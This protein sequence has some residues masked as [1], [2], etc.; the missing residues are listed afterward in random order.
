[1]AGVV[2]IIIQT[3]DESTGANNSIIGSFT[4]L[5][6]AVALASEAVAAGKGI[7]DATIGST[8]RYADSVREISAVSGTSTE[9]TSRLI[10]VTEKL[11]VQQGTLEMA[12][13]FLAKEGIQPT[14]QNMAALSDQY[15]KLAPGVERDTF[16]LQNFGRSG[17]DMAVFMSQGSSAIMALNE[18]VNKNLILTAQQVEAFH[19][20]S[21]QQ[22]QVSDNWKGITTQFSIALMPAVLNVTTAFLRQSESM[23]IATDMGFNNIHMTQQQTAE[24]NN[25]IDAENNYGAA[26]DA[27]DRHLQNSIDL[28]AQQSDTVKQQ[29]KDINSLIKDIEN[30][31]KEQERY[32]TTNEQLLA[33]KADIIGAYD[34]GRISLA[35]EN[36]ELQTVNAALDKNAADHAAWAKQVIFSMLQARVAAQETL[37]PAHAGSYQDFLIKAGE[38]MGMFD[39][40]T[41]QVMQSVNDSISSLNTSNA[42]QALTTIQQELQYLQANGVVNIQVN[43]T[44]SGSINIPAGT[45]TGA[46]GS[47]C[48]FPAGTLIRMGDGGD[49][50][51]EDVQ[52]GDRVKAFDGFAI[53]DAEVT[54]LIA[55]IRDHLY[56]LTFA[57]GTVL[58]LTREHPIFTREGWKSV[59]PEAT[60]TTN[61]GLD[62]KTLQVGDEILTILGEFIA[63]TNIEYFYGNVQTYNLTGV[64]PCN[65]YF[66]NGYLVHNKNCA[67]GGDFIVPPGYPGD[68]YP[69]S[70]TSGE[71]VSITP[72]GRSAEGGSGMTIN[73]FNSQIVMPESMTMDDVMKA[74]NHVGA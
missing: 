49:K 13:K 15:L 72:L 56:V 60:R 21:I 43:V 25:I 54:G 6:S 26:L 48:C 30:A 9:E 63:I 57:D 36:D 62:V 7:Y 27:S 38:Q 31:S 65:T 37:D 47:M 5:Q 71:H 66:A 10:D 3:V 24:V 39:S 16:L 68:T 69:V 51:I 11:G 1:M 55:P 41:A 32:N 64:E 19:N 34:S 73:L 28:G 52:M 67:A 35:K 33:K 4:E 74:V 42:Q 23:Q 20:L 18:Q 61:P 29:S 46:P 58:K 40:T 53:V 45:V 70:L 59:F 17:L 44:Q 14:M 22:A 8:M 12:M 2:E 50:N